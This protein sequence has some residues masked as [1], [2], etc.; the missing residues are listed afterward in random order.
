M[1]DEIDEEIL[2]EEEDILMMD[3][4]NEEE[5]EIS[6]YGQTNEED[7]RFDQFVGSLQ[8]I[9][10][11]EEFEELQNSFFKSYCSHFDNT[12]ENKLIYTDIF[13]KYKNTVESYIETQLSEMIPDFDMEEYANV[14]PDR[15]DE[16]DDQLLELLI[17]FSDFSTFKELMVSFKKMIIAQ[18]P[19]HRSAKAA[20]LEKEL[21]VK[22][23]LEIPEGLELLHVNG[24]KLKWLEE[25][26]K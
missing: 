15:K 25:S 1:E 3:D 19:K 4:D 14:L 24:N 7:D 10:I 22:E 23:N 18:T 6:C 16:I 13:K 2:E 17:S 20:A 8:E 21:L 26:K 11:N 12:E 5:F 9:V